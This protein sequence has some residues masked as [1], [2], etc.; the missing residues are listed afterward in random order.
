MK[1]IDE[2]LFRMVVGSR[3]R[4][5][6]LMRGH[7]QEEFAEILGIEPSKLCKI[8]KGGQGIG[9]PDAILVGRALDV[10]LDDLFALPHSNESESLSL[11]L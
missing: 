9:G 11:D 8:E 6:R 1:Q 4:Y 2:K 5:L 3:I 10:S 7:S